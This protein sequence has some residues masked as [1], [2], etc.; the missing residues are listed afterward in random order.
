MLML[1]VCFVCDEKSQ[2]H[3][4]YFRSMFCTRCRELERFILTAFDIIQANLLAC[5]SHT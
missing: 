1:A 4:A 3:N 5:V 2:L